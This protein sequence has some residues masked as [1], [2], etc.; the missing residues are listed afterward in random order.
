MPT[1]TVKLSPFLAEQIFFGMPVPEWWTWL[2]NRAG[3]DINLVLDDTDVHDSLRV[4]GR[5]LGIDPHELADLDEHDGVLSTHPPDEIV[6]AAGRTS[7]ARLGRR[8]S[9]RRR[10]M[11]TEEPIAVHD[12]ASLQAAEH[13]VR[14]RVLEDAKVRGVRIIDPAR[15]WVSPTVIVEPGVTLWPDTWLFGRTVVRAGAVLH[16]GCHLTDTRVGAGAVLRPYTVAD[17]ADIGP[18]AVVGPFAHLRPGTVLLEK[19]RVGNFVETKNT[20]LGAGSKANHLAYLGDATVGAGVNFSAGA[21]TCNYD[22]A[23][24][25]RTEIGDGAFIGTN[26]SLVAP[27]R[28]GAGALVAAG[29]VVTEDVPDGALAVERATLR[30][31]PG[32]GAALLERNRKAA[33]DAKEAREHARRRELSARPAAAAPAWYTTMEGEV[34]HIPAPADL[35]PE[36]AAATPAPAA[37]PVERPAPRAPEDAPDPGADEDPG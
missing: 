34:T 23:Q 18:D 22:G 3:L 8:W 10:L 9:G 24:K 14:W 16:P 20:T 36:P 28:I 31:L 15:T 19:A 25:H 2:C 30:R 1:A 21:I 11:T 12:L 32:K 17:G 37:P 6:V 29:S 4:D 5:Y 7:R 26:S 13:A 27:V 33:V 35:P